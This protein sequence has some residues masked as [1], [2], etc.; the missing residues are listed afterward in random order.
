MVGAG[1]EPDC[2]L[3]PVATA[4]SKTRA[5]SCR[6]FTISN[7]IR[8]IKITGTEI[9]PPQA[10]QRRVRQSKPP[11]RASEDNREPTPLEYQYRWRLASKYARQARGVPLTQSCPKRQ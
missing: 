6:F 8:R 10:P 9:K 4:I 11:R 5:R 2:G 7:F 1:D 3:A